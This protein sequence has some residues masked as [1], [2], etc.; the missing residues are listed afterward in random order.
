MTLE[1]TQHGFRSKG[2]HENYSVLFSDSLVSKPQA[3]LYNV[4]S[5]V[6][7]KRK[8][9]KKKKKGQVGM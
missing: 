8:K 9:K 3:S 7:V 6:L 2:H 1:Y 5:L 4:T